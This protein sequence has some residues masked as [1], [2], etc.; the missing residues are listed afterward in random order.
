MNGFLFIGLIG[1]TA[2]LVVNLLAILVFGKSHAAFFTDDWWSTWFPNYV[3]WLT[4]TIIGIAARGKST[5]PPFGDCH[6][7]SRHRGIN[8]L[9]TRSC[10]KKG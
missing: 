2:I 8:N 1:F 7:F 9:R 5:M 4:F 6:L 3:A 10:A